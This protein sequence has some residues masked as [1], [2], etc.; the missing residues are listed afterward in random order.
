MKKAWM[1]VVPALLLAACDRPVQNIDLQC[2]GFL[3]R[4]HADIY[5]DR[6]VVTVVESDGRAE[7]FADAGI[8]DALA[9]HDV[10]VIMTKVPREAP[11]NIDRITYAGPIGNSDT[12]LNLHLLY[13]DAAT[14]T[15]Q[16]GVQFGDE[17]VFYGCTVLIPYEIKSK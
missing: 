17:P 15:Y 13:D 14:S 12:T 5:H 4:M 2:G 10:R 9:A 6:A 16:Y 7:A 8:P 1:I 11:G 3:W